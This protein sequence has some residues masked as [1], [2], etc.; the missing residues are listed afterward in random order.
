MTVTEYVSILVVVDYTPLGVG[1]NGKLV[2]NAAV[3]D[4]YLLI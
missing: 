4:I 1:M 3:K 2:I